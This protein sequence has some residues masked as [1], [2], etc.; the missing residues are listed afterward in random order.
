LLLGVLLSAGCHDLTAPQTL[1]GSWRQADTFPGNSLSFT[2]SATGDAITGS[3]TWTGEACCDG[4]E[5]IAGTEVAGTVS[6]DFAFVTRGGA[7]LPPRT[8]HF[9]GTLTGQNSLVGRFDGAPSAP[10]VVFLR[11][12]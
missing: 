6:L 4:T 10:D 2:L 5:T 11:T 3:G 8:S 12:N 7:N 1:A 9:T